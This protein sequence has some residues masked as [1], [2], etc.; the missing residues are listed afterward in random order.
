MT[1]KILLD[2]NIVLWAAMG[3]KKLSREAKRAIERADSVHVSSVSIWEI[4]IKVALGKLDVDVDEFLR[5]LRA[6]SFEQLSLTWEH[7]RM[8]GRLPL[9]HRD[10]FDRML[11]AQAMSEPLVLLTHDET[12]SAYGDLIKIA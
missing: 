12:L 9:H 4:G 1:L 10:P 2:T 5:S 3:S 8:L 7:G 6:R 11:V